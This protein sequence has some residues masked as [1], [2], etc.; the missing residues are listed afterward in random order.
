MVDKVVSV[1]DAIAI[2]KDGDTICVSGFVGIGTPEALIKGLQDR[3]AEAQS[4]KDLSLLFA[5]AP[6]DGKDRGLNRLNA[7]GLIKRAIGGHWSLVP[8]LGKLAVENK[9]QAYNLPLGCISQLYRDIAAQKPGMFSKVG[10]NTFVDPRQIG[11]EIGRT[12][13]AGWQRVAVLPI[14]PHRCGLRARH[15][16]RQKR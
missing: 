5:A 13:R 15:H 8:K 14:Y 4:P 6:G 12:E 10:L 3:H 7:P 9:I 11:R 2:I 1:E 16:R